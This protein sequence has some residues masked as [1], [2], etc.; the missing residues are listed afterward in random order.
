LGEI[1]TDYINN[2]EKDAT[3]FIFMV[4]TGITADDDKYDEYIVIKDEQSGE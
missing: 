1:T 4:P 2:S 3:K